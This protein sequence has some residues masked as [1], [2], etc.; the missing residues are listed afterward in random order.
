M[1]RL[2]E[3]I[4][5]G[6]RIKEVAKDCVAKYGIPEAKATEEMPISETEMAK[7]E[8]VYS[9]NMERMVS[10]FEKLQNRVNKLEMKLADREMEQ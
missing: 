9:Q 5:R 3:I 2:R 4:D 8:A 6:K 7:M 1:N 10:M